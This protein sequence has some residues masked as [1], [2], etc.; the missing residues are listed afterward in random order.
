MALS[1]LWLLGWSVLTG[2]GRREGAEAPQDE[3]I[4]QETVAQGLVQLTPEAVKAAE[5]RLVR[6]GE[7]PNARQI[8]T[9]GV[10]KADENKV[11]HISAPVAGR[12]LE[13]RVL[14]G[15]VVHPGQLLAV[16]KN[17]E[18]AK[19]HADFIHEYH[20]NE[21]DIKQAKTKLELALQRL[22]REKKLYEDGISPKMDYLQAQ[23]DEKIAR[24]ELEGLEE[25]AI[26]IRSEAKAMLGV[27]G[28]RLTS[29]HY[30]HAEEIISTSPLRAPKGGVI[31]QKTITVGDQVTPEQLMYEIA[32][33]G[34]VWLDLTI[35]PKDLDRIRVG[36]PVV[37]R[38][39]ALPG[40]T[41]SGRI[42]YILPAAQQPSATFIARA[43]LQNSVRSGRNKML[44]PGMA[45][46][47]TVQVGESTLFPFVPDEAVQTFN[48]QSFVFVPE[49]ET[50]PGQRFRQQLVTLG[51]RVQG[52][53]LVDSGLTPGQS[54]VGHGS[55][56]LKAELLKSRFKEE[57]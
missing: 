41:F 17:L 52:G 6:V 22:V 18:V 55:F 30:T 38:S 13:D 1:L 51:Q 19:I 27:Y 24:S 25:H 42:N 26:H 32:D 48:R 36:Q 49:G 56:V 54:V 2:C 11:F 44:Q 29:S 50:T 5:I 14:L 28:N 53:Y 33:L 7:Q 46:I 15:D 45:G 37:F 9:T 20:Q 35:Y 31:T 21:I 10:I 40:Q 8:Q 47:A 16:V 3:A 4:E 57:E 23:A 43:F 39:D 34:Q 12:V